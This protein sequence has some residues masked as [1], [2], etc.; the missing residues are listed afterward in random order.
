MN[1]CRYCQRRFRK[2][3]LCA[4]KFAYEF[5]FEEFFTAILI[6]KRPTDFLDFF[7]QSMKVINE[8]GLF[9]ESLNPSDIVRNNLIIFVHDYECF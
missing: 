2:T 7:C 5:I 8:H 6:L 9:G 1:I 3:H 4:R